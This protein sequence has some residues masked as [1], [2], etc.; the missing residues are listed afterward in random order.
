[1]DI[2]Y[3]AMIQIVSQLV[4]PMGRIGGL[5]L[6]APLFSSKQIP[7]RVKVVFICAISFACSMFIPKELSL[8]NFSGMYV[9]Y[10]AEEVAFGFLMG[11]IMLLVFQ[12]FVL[13]GQI[14]SMQSGLGFAVMM[15]PSSTASVPLIGQYYLMMASL[16]FLALNGHLVLLEALINSFKIMPIGALVADN[17]VAEVISFS[18]WMFKEGVLVSIPAII[19]LLLVSLS[20]GIMTRV[21]PQLNIFSLGFPITLVMAIAVIQVCMTSLGEQMVASIEHGLNL[22]IRMAR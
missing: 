20:F 22:V 4:W 1:M 7:K 2:D 19:S 9:V 5:L 13:S 18:G 11:F 3:Q 16:I 6:V 10:M 12:V 21:A 15:D 14:V 17:F 8:A